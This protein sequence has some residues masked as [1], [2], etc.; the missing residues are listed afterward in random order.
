MQNKLLLTFAPKG[1]VLGVMILVLGSYHSVEQFL[2][3]TALLVLAYSLIAGIFI[4]YLEHK[5]MLRLDRLY[6][7]LLNIRF[8]RKRDLPRL[9]HPHAYHKQ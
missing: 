5:K 7:I 6:T 9:R 4:E 3:N 2:I 8:G 1:M